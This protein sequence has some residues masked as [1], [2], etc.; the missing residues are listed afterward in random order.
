MMPIS[1]KYVRRLIHRCRLK[2]VVMLITSSGEIRVRVRAR[3]GRET[4]QVFSA[5]SSERSRAHDSTLAHLRHFAIQPPHSQER[6][7]A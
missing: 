7:A 3:D 4:V 2:V 5:A 1:E 6:K